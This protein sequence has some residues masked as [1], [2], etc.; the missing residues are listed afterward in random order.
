VG[1]SPRHPGRSPG[2]LALLAGVVGAKLVAAA[3]VLGITRPAPHM[4]LVW[5]GVAGG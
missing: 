2:A 4:L 5:C 3:L 1:L